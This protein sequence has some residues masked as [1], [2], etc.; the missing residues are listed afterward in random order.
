MRKRSHLK[1]KN[2]FYLCHE[3]DYRRRG[4]GKIFSLKRGVKRGKN[5]VI[6]GR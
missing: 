2:L 3:R 5:L 6:S 4:E 1:R